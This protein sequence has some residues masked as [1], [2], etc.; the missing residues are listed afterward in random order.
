MFCHVTV[1]YWSFAKF[2]ESSQRILT[3]LKPSA[4]PTGAKK[5]GSG[6]R[7]MGSYFKNP[8][9]ALIFWSMDLLSAL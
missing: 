8:Q 6:I 2:V 9:A 1:K 3:K 7:N 5:Q 4:K